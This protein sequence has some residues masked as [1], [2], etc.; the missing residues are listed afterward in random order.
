MSFFMA[1]IYPWLMMIAVFGLAV[2]VHEFGHM[3][4]ALVRGVG[5]ES[6]AIGM[7]PKIFAWHW[8]GIEFSLRWL[9]IGGFVKLQGMVREEPEA[10]T[11]EAQP[12]AAET[13]DAAAEARE[14][15]G[16]TLTVH[17]V[18]VDDGQDKSGKTIT[19]STYDD[20]LAL[21]DKGF[22]TKFLVFAGGVF[23][24]FLT[25]IVA[26]AVFLYLP[27][28][29]YQ[30]KPS[31]EKVEAG[32]EAAQAGL[33]AGDLI[34][35]VNGNPVI[36]TNDMDKIFAK[37]VDAKKLKP[38]TDAFPMTL[39]IARAESHQTITL[40]KTTLSSF[41]KQVEF[42][43][44]PIIGELAPYA[45]A[46]KAGIKEGDRVLSING[47]PMPSFTAMADVIKGS[48]GK[49]LN[50]V[51]QRADQQLTFDI[52]PVEHTDD[53]TKGAIGITP[54]SE[55]KG[56]TREEETLGAAIFH[57]PLRTVQQMGFLISKQYDFFKRAGF[58]QIKDN[59]GGP[60]A[61]FD[62]TRRQAK[63]G[64]SNLLIWF[65]N[66]NLL[67]MMFNLLPIPVLDGG[68]ILL[69]AIEGIVR[70][71]VSPKI[72][73]P[74]YKAFFLFFISLMVIISLLDIKRFLG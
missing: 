31:I 56:V 27:H 42:L 33:Q 16:G 48:L 25:A 50:I 55:V 17:D 3:F 32:T 28:K 63:Q 11:P 66:L 30:F 34:T 59:L 5:V 13:T 57:A 38:D 35:T 9:P 74:V 20:L 44:P 65:I 10:A 8:R 4:F 70:R 58:K 45:P 2:F 41:T 37:E 49:T 71:P 21:A 26:M 73:D 7:G 68:F 19:E 54:G 39:E 60:I 12:A 52:K 64:F 1:N 69:A 24:N 22:V 14:E 36:S 61:I 6:F 46:E 53:F 23:M 67:L 51:I 72:L 43:L 15:P 40:S 18:K 29:A 62:M 47:K